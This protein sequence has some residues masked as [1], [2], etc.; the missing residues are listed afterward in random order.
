MRE[1]LIL[2]AGLCVTVAWAMILY[3]MR[4]RKK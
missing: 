3:D 1:P 2:L 4:R